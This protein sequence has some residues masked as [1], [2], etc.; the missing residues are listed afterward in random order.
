MC[1]AQ[2]RF[3]LVKLPFQVIQI[4]IAEEQERHWNRKKQTNKE[5]NKD[6]T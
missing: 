3:S 4:R 1:V 2:K 5:T 6:T